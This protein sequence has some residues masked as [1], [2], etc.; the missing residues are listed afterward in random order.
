MRTEPR[1]TPKDLNFL[2]F[3]KHPQF[4]SSYSNTVWI[5]NFANFIPLHKLSHGSIPK[6]N[7]SSCS[8][9]GFSHNKVWFFLQNFKY[10][11]ADFGI[12]SWKGFKF[13]QFLREYLVGWSK[14]LRSF[15]IGL[16]LVL[17]GSK[18][19]S[20]FAWKP[21]NLSL[22]RWVFCSLFRFLKSWKFYLVLACHVYGVISR[23]ESLCVVE[24]L[25]I[26]LKA[27]LWKIVEKIFFC[28]E[29]YVWICDNSLKAENW[30]RMIIR[31]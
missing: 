24:T 17:W 18:G 22:L 5:C 11:F 13:V 20:L 12:F 19:I 28:F 25:R 6:T 26:C 31:S 15:S 10:P 2:C 7:F 27:L 1:T 14:S 23:E 9:Y 30:D 21:W 4:S 8:V 3:C 16:A 29:R